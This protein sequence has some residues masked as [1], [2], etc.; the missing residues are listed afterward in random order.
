MNRRWVALGGVT[1]AAV[2]WIAGPS[3]GRRMEFFRV[4][5]VEFAGMHHLK[6]AVA[7]PALR[8]GRDASILDNLDSIA[9]RAER[10]GGVQQA[11]VGRRFPGTLVIRIRETPP[12]ALVPRGTRLALMDSAGRVLPYDPAHS[13]PDLPI[14]AKADGKVGTLLRRM[15]R[16]DPAF[17]GRVITAARAGDDVVV[18]VDG[19]RLLFRPDASLEEMHA[20]IAVAQDLVRKGEGY[21]ELDGRFAGYVVV[22]GTGA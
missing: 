5:R 21:A 1:L 19:R 17:F 11:E 18:V 9:A 8:L 13:A 22:R 14:A 4:R 3:L 16:L 12:V 15:Q 6:P 20:V 7:L 2:L 10:I